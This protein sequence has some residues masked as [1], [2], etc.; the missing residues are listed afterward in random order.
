MRPITGKFLNRESRRRGAYAL[1]GAVLILGLAAPASA[2]QNAATGQPVSLVRDWSSKHILFTNGAS[3]E[4]VVA[5]QRDPRSWQNWLYRNAW[6]FRSNAAQLPAA[7]ADQAQLDQAQL[8]R[9]RLDQAGLS[10]LSF[11]G[12]PGLKAKTKNKHSKIDWAMSL[13][14]GPMAIAETPA[15][16]SFDV[17]KPP[18]CTNDFVVYVV[19]ATPGAGKQANILAFNNLYSGPAPALCNRTTPKFLWS[20]AV[21]TGSVDLS[22]V[23]SLDG[24]KVGFIETGTRAL[25]HVLTWV[26]G[27]GTDATTGAVAPGSGSSVTTLDYTNLTTAGCTANTGGNP[28][29]SPYVDYGTDTA[30]LV[31]SNGIL[32]RIKGVFKGTPALDICITV[33][34]GAALTSPVY[35]SVSNK[36]F[37]SD[38]KTVYAYT[39]G[40]TSFTLAG[41][42]QVAASTSG[43][44]LSPYVDSTDGFVYAFSS[45]NTAGTNSIVSQMPTSLASHTDAPIGPSTGGSSANYILDGDFDNKYYANGISAGTLYACGTQAASA[46]RPALYAIS[47]GTNGVMNT[48]PAMSNDV[49]IN[50]S[51]NPRSI[52]SP[53]LEFYDGTNDRLFGG[54]GQLASTAGANLM[55]MWNI[56]SRITSN[57]AVPAAIA[58]NELGGSSGITIDNV[59]TSPQASSIYFGTQAQGSAAPCGAGL[60][61]AVKLTQSGLQ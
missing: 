19:S 61:C 49:N 55:T 53:L 42:I 36:V 4:A 51:T 43:I 30:Y 20:Y 2:Q 26:A 7:D 23:L 58:I 22:P 15:K 45:S 3:P 52:C 39:P 6:M 40:A 54:V 24:K 31:A 38:G 59:S 27:Q 18:D 13:G 35:D 48:T 29:G 46:N 8:D 60:Y 11:R 17:N 33:S 9:P 5:T 47:F 57:T 14:G 44:I 56:N 37:V 21:G 16:F 32:Y 41:S 12:L 50:S 34:A 10:G 1:L 28:N 25:F